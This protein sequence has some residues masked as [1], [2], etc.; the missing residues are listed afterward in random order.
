M[1][2]MFVNLPPGHKSCWHAASFPSLS[3][4]PREKIIPIDS[5]VVPI[6]NPLLMQMSVD[7]QHPL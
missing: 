5:F 2:Q 1:S 6:H 4:Q 7:A 3:V